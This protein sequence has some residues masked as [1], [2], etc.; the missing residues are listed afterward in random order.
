MDQ[1]FKINKAQKRVLKKEA[2]L[3]DAGLLERLRERVPF[4]HL[5]THSD[6]RIWKD[7]PG[8]HPAEAQ[9]GEEHVHAVPDP[10]REQGRRLLQ[11][12]SELNSSI[13]EA[14]PIKAE[15]RKSKVAQAT[16]DLGTVGGGGT[17]LDVSN[18]LR[19]VQ[20]DVAL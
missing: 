11:R 5:R 12:D 8:I 6:G 16:L 3:S 14:L 18:D 20:H 9:G 7:Y 2:Q 13:E 1:A 19:H 17:V 4:L 15:R 10:G